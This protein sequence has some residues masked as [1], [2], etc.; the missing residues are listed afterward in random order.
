[1]CAFSY[2][3]YIYVKESHRLDLY[4]FSKLIFYS[5]FFK[6]HIDPIVCWRNSL[7]GLGEF[8]FFLQLKKQYFFCIFLSLGG[9]QTCSCI[10]VFEFKY[11]FYSIRQ[12]NRLPVLCGPPIT[13][14]IYLG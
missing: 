10:F 14:K 3:F 2:S 1:M 11:F 7:A 9:L 4:I 13:V 8:L 12:G 5:F 6:F